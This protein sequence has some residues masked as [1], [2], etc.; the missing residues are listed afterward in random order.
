LT[1]LDQRQ[2]EVPNTIE[3]PRLYLRP[4]RAGDGAWY[5]A[6]SR[7][8]REHLSRYESENVAMSIHDEDEAE[9]VVRDLAQEWS[10][11]KHMFLGAFS[12]ESDDFVAQIYIGAV[13]QGVAA[14]R[15]G[16]FAD[17]DHEG[18][19]FVT[20]AVRGALAFIFGHLHGMRVG[21][22]CDDSNQRS[23]RV[24]ERC[25]FVSEGH[26]REVKRLGDG[27]VTGTRLFG[28]LKREYDALGEGGGATRGDPSE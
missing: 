6:M 27:T 25:G 9:L 7:R 16:Y 21:I 3:T 22:E 1:T 8:N 24:A 15:I 10:A 18:H 13:N 28:M 4:Y 5:Y 14:Y 12:K 23:I 19:G 11:R 2:P 17:V 20:E 26:I